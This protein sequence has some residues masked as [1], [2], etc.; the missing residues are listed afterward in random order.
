MGVGMNSI[1]LVLLTLTIFISIPKEGH[2][3]CGTPSLMNNNY[4]G[5]PYVRPGVYPYPNLNY[6]SFY[7]PTPYYFT[8]H[9]QSPYMPQWMYNC[10][11]CG[12]N[13]GW[14]NPQNQWWNNNTQGNVHGPVS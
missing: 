9:G 6:H 5:T 12:G 14:Q 3:F 1:K 8:P 2:S 10:P 4:Y 11:N 7:G 13:Q